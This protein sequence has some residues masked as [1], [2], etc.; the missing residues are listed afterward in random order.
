MS[1]EFTPEEEGVI[2]RFLDLRERTRRPPPNTSP[3]DW[4]IE[5]HEQGIIATYRRVT[6]IGSQKDFITWILD[7]D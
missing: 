7:E 2:E 1:E 3:A 6:F 4:H 5:P